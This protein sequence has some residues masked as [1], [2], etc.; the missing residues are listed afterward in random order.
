MSIPVIPESAPFSAA[1]RAWLNGFFAGVLGLQSHSDNIAS[2]AFAAR[3][4]D[5]PAAESLDEQ[6][7]WHDPALP[8][9]ERLKLAN[10]QPQPLKLMAAM[11]QLDCGACG[12]VCRTYS[13]AI[14]DG[15]E[16]DL[17]RCSPGGSE[18][19]KA[20]KRLLADNGAD[21]LVVKSLASTNGHSHAATNGKPANGNVAQGAPL[22]ATSAAGYTRANPFS[23]RLVQSYRLNHLESAKDTRHVILDLTG[24]G[25]EYQPGDSLGVLPHNCPDLVAGV[26]AALGASGQE[27]VLSPD[28]DRKSLRQ[29]LTTDYTLTRPRP[30]LVEQLARCAE[31]M[32][33]A[34]ALSAMSDG[35]V[36]ELL[37]AHDVCDLLERF[38]SAR[39]AISELLGALARLQPR[40]YSISSS[41]KAHP[42]QVHLTVG[43]VRYEARGK[44]F[45]GVASNFLGVRCEPGDEIKLY[46]QPS[47]FRLPADPK[48]PIIMIGPGTGIAPFRA[49][50]EERRALSSPGENWLFF[51]DQHFGY[52]FLYRAE[53]DQYLDSGLLTRLDTAF[54]RDQADKI[55]VQ[56]RLLEQGAEVW[57]WLERGAYLYVCG[58]AKRMA[59]DVDAALQQIVARYG[60]RDPVEAKSFLQLLAKNRRYQ[61]DVY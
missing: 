34:H 21:Q 29:A 43:V 52:D 22:K 42:N 37:A 35:E 5:S 12:Y 13:R 30:A 9:E 11:A 20:L 60:C 45:H 50:L 58:D 33:E 59:A 61:R 36:E 56:H 31:S 53:I 4:P 27:E 54:S 28:G 23:A 2:T 46:V 10:D 16:A 1:Q 8:L 26:L 18:T 40:L 15:S 38:S 48:A 24:S 44:T 32:T 55:Y 25:I 6:F 41:L 47:R 19:V 39:P 57:N 51:G 14:A 3:E 7:P 17:S 49:F